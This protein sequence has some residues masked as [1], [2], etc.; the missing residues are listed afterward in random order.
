[1]SGGGGGSRGVRVAAEV[2][3]AA[4]LCDARDCGT[5]DGGAPAGGMKDATKDCCRET[6]GSAREVGMETPLEVEGGGVP[7]TRL[8]A[9][10]NARLSWPSVEGGGGNGDGPDATSGGTMGGAHHAASCSSCLQCV[11]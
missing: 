5:L 1:M 2:D 7:R 8:L 6:M 11:L 9:A 10:A 4:E 3:G